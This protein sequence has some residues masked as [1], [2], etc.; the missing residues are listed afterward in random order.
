MSRFIEHVTTEGE[1]WDLLAFRY[2]SDVN[3]MGLLIENNPHV[4]ITP[5]FPSGLKIRIPIISQP[6]TDT[7][8]PPWRR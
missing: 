2:Y 5:H 8:L 6:T 1:R 3:Q 4:P 7:D